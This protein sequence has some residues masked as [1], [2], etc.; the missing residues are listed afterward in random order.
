ML[1]GLFKG[2]R[3][4]PFSN[5]HTSISLVVVCRFRQ[6]LGWRFSAIY[7]LFPLA[8]FRAFRDA[9]HSRFRCRHLKLCL[10][11]FLKMLL[12]ALLQI[13]TRVFN[14]WKSIDLDSVWVGDS[15]AYQLSLL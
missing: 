4:G 2:A 5:L 1:T 8:C 11:N 13:Y 14:L 9:P 3:F 6:F 7:I 10:P 15:R 12:L